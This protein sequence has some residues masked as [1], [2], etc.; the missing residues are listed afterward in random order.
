MINSNVGKSFVE[1]LKSFKMCKSLVSST[2]DILWG[3]A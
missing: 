3:V 1:E 2:I